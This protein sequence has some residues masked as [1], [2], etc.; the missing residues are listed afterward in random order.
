[1]SR[2]A[3]VNGAYVPVAQAQ[4]SAE[5]RGFQFADGVY[6]VW[7]LRNGRLIDHAPHMA[8]LHRSLAE[9]AIASPM[10]D[11]ALQAVIAETVRRNRVRNGIVYLQITR[12]A[13]PRDHTFPARA[14]PTLVIYARAMDQT[15]LAHRHKEGVGVITAP[16][17]RWGRCDIKTV[18]LLPN[19][20]ARQ[21]AKEAGASEAW[22]LDDAGF[23]TEGTASNAWIVDAAGVLRTRA[24]GHDILPGATR[25]ALA[26]LA[27]DRQ[28]RLSEQPFTLDDVF[29]A[30][31]AFLTSAGAAVTPVVACN[32]RAIANGIPG[33]ITRAL[34]AAYR[35]DGASTGLTV[36]APQNPDV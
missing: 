3:Y 1:M 22:L 31:E 11:G 4:V 16:D 2:I 28:M 5:D 18:S 27:R 25:A 35:E 24:L 19:V 7:P 26:R 32:G 36:A 20:L 29:A 8:R 6:E 30:R 14:S 10:G 9:L 17:I 15:A 23:I 12:G 13:A 34:Q 21:A 33:P